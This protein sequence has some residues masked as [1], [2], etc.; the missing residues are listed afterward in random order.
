M[1]IA[2]SFVCTV[3]DCSQ[4]YG[5][6]NLKAALAQMAEQLTRNEKVEGS[7]PS[8][9]S[10]AFVV[11][12]ENSRMVSSRLGFDSLHWLHFHD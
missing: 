7:I 10:R 6:R 12:W 1:H 4:H 2:E 8:G 5:R 11:Q 9:G 3:R